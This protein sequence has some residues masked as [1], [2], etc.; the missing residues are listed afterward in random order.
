VFTRDGN[1]ILGYNDRGRIQI[2]RAPS[3]AEIEA[4]DKGQTQ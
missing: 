4:V 2:W 3:W 1:K